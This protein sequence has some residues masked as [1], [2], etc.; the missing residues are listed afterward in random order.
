M[1]QPVYTFQVDVEPHDRYQQGYHP[2]SLWVNLLTLWV[3]DSSHQFSHEFSY[4][5]H[6]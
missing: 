5:A 3:A 1:E 6:K 2:Q 4:L